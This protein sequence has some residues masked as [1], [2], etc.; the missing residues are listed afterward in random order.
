MAILVCSSRT[1]A[2][3]VQEEGLKFADTPGGP[4]AGSKV[5]QLESYFSPND[6]SY[7]DPAE[8]TKELAADRKR[9]PLNH[10]RHGVPSPDSS[11][12]YLSLEE[13]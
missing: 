4:A 7:A 13:A 12:G 10:G 6:F 2:W 9:P 1:A 11:A 5:W 3:A 8:R